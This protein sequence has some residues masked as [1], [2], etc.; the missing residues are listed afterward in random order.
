MADWRLAA[1]AFSNFAIA[2]GVGGSPIKS[3]YARR[4]KV[5]PPAGP[6]GWRPLDSSFARMKLSSP[7][8]GQSACFTFGGVSFLT[9]CHA[10]CLALRSARLNSSVAALPATTSF[11]QGMPRFTH[12]VRSAIASAGSLPPGGISRSTLLYSTASTSRLVSGFPGIAAA[13]LSP[14]LSTPA[15]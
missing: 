14:P 4:I 10:Q 8:A 1:H 9:G 2:S 5:R 11:G 15:R 7:L 6:A 12:S 13:P 3:K